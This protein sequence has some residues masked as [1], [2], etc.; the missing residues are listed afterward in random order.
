MGEEGT[1]VVWSE[2][3]E[4]RKGSEWVGWGQEGLGVGGERT[5]GVRSWW[6]RDGRG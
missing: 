2:W 4:C 1:G 5:G 3:R 6:V